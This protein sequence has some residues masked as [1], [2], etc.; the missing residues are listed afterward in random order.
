MR[1]VQGDD[2]VNRE[3]RVAPVDQHVNRNCKGVG[4]VANICSDGVPV[5]LGH[6][7]KYDDWLID[8]G[9]DEIGRDK[10]KNLKIQTRFT[11]CF[12]PGDN[13]DDNVVDTAHEG[14]GKGCR[15]PS[16]ELGVFCSG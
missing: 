15:D 3:T 11:A 9:H 8:H 1:K 2:T 14:K 13:E 10:V 6:H 16:G 4:E 7:Q 5:T 12:G